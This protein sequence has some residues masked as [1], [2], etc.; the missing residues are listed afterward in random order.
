MKKALNLILLFILLL[1]AAAGGQSESEYDL[2]L[3][4]NEFSLSKDRNNLL[5]NEK[6][7]L[8]TYAEN[9]GTKDASGFIVFYRGTQL[10]GQAE[11]S[12]TAKGVK[13][14]V[15]IDFAVPLGNFNI[16]AKII[17]A[18][19]RDDNPDNNTALTQMYDG[20]KD[21][22]GDGLGDKIDPDDD[23]DGVADANEAS[24]GTDPLKSDTDGDGVVDALDE[25]PLDPL[26][27]KKEAPKPPVLP[28][29]E[30]KP[31]PKP[32]AKEAVQPVA[33]K[34]VA[35]EKKASIIATILGKKDD[36]P[37]PELVQDFYASPAIELLKQVKINV[38][39]VNWNTYNFS[40]TTNSPDVDVS[41]LDYT[42]SFSNGTEVKVNGEHRFSGTGQYFV[43]LKVK[44][45]WDNYLFDSVTVNVAFWSVFNYWLWLIVLALMAVGFLYAYGRRHNKEEVGPAEPLEDKEDPSTSSGQK[46]DKRE[47][48]Q[49]RKRQ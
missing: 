5:V 2:A 9:R 46:E 12:L 33:D 10:L 13:D 42:W 41:K 26:K 27:S 14:E 20:Q 43:S 45:P 19:P 1:P 48:R 36:A 35:P 11:V 38:L 28:K 8:Y 30:V 40:F 25:F 15:Y 44:G 6:V 21:S 18:V 7:R 31:T 23:N 49:P 29:V 3:R 32:V 34:P 37:K 39:Q 47:L 16:L 4:P 22:D 17:S 24:L